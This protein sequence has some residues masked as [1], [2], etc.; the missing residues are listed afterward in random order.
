MRVLRATRAAHGDGSAL[1][2][3]LL[4]TGMLLAAQ[5]AHPT[6]IA[7]DVMVAA[8]GLQVPVTPPDSRVSVAA[9]VG[10]ASLVRRPQADLGMVVKDLRACFE[11][12]Q[13]AFGFLNQCMQDAGYAVTPLS[14]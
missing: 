6:E 7:G 1:R 3:W 9:G 2:V 12:S 4:A 14:R 10:G 11:K 8:S 5:P 13:A